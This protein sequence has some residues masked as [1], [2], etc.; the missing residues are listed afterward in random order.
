MRVLIRFLRAGPAGAVEQK[1]KL[2]DG[3]SVT[4]GRATDQV[5]QLKDRRVAL[6]HAQIILRNGQPVLISRVPGGVLVNGTLQREARLRAGDVVTLGAN[7][8]RILQPPA[9]CELAFSFELDPDARS[10]GVALELPRLRL[11][12]LGFAKRRWSWGLFLG[13]LLLSLAIPSAGVRSPQIQERL[14]ASLLPDDHWW[15]PGP[16]SRVHE[17]LG[18]QCEACHQKPF[19]RVRNDACLTCHAANLHQH[20]PQSGSGA[21]AP[22]ER[23]ASCHAEHQEPATL[24][25]QDSAV[26][27]NC[28]GDLK[29]RAPATLITARVTDFAAD[30]PGFDLPVS[31]ES[32]LRFPHDLHL[33]KDGVRSPVGDTVLGCQD[34]HALE[35]GGAR[36]RPVQ[37]QRDCGQCHLLDFDS[38]YPERTVPHGDAT[39]V[40]EFLLD[41]YSRRYLEA[42]ADPRAVP[43]TARRAGQQ[44]A[45]PERERLLRTAREQ[46][47]IV[48]QD[49]FERRSCAQ[50]HEVTRDASGAPDQWQIRPVKLSSAWLKGAA[51]SHAAHSTA[52]TRCE[53]CHAAVDSKAASDVLL[54]D[55]ATCRECH[56]G[57]GDAHA[58]PPDRIT[59]TCILC[60]GFHGGDNPL[61][62]ARAAAR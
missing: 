27:A 5:V 23:C 58:T 6:A 18:T 26:C 11:A 33:A 44:L 59:S 32:G 14:R 38:A 9:G 50:C 31:E 62:Q 34:C 55:I 36:F 41:Y 61:W 2:Y 51:F 48:T 4:L 29:A 24:V 8:L 46:A 49:L 3:E 30:H 40:S 42:Y 28:H 13:M 54:P 22:E 21:V 37:M 15:S 60:H 45:A 7:V 35:P 47:A 25:R 20:W 43:G 10:Q 19:Q 57:G 56:A 16:L 12:E 53:T 1:D 39:A 17:V 52:L